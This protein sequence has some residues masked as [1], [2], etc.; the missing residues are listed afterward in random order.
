MKQENQ[1]KELQRRTYL[2]YHKDGLIDVIIGLSVL[3][4]GLN[5]A[6]ESVVFSILGWIWFIL[7][8]PLK[9]RITYPR[10][11]YVEWKPEQRISQQWAIS[12]VLGLVVLLVGIVVL[13]GVR[14]GDMPAEV[15]SFLKQFHMLL[16]GILMALIA[17]AAGLFT[18]IRR[19]Y[20][21]AGL[22]LLIILA[23]TWLEIEPAFYV[24]TI[25]G[26]ILLWGVWLLGH[27]VRDYPL[28]S[29]EGQNV[30]S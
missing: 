30:S 5:M 6:L 20:T 8:M 2:A 13:L 3:G 26:L 11:G 21:Y 12:I 23:G 17:V 19:L 18:G 16:L 10:F 28:T 9:K 24:M 25:G 14:S 4:F 15:I 29:G 27:F 22:T 1:L 7:Y